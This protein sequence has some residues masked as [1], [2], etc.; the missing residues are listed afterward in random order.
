LKD[1]P[2][3]AARQTQLIEVLDRQSQQMSRLLDDLLDASR[4]TQNKIELR[5]EPVD[6]HTIIEEAVSAARPLMEAHGLRF[7]LVHDSHPLVIDG[8]A[9]RL[10]Q[11]CVNLLTN[12]AK[13]TPA[14][15]AVSLEANHDGSSAVIRVRDDGV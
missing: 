4:V 2:A 3:R 10:Q 7:S 6:L 14:G 15:G 11:V 5:K 13:Y 8:D 9:S 1:D 12:A